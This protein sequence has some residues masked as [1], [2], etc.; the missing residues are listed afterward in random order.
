M[1]YI[2]VVQISSSSSD[3]VDS[4]DYDTHT[5]RCMRLQRQIQSNISLT[6]CLLGTY[7]STYHDKNEPRTSPLSG[8]DWV[9]KTLNT[10]GESHRMFRIDESIFNTLHDLLVTNYGLKSSNHI[11]SME[12]LAI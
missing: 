6:A 4:E 8:Y 5:L 12:S 9:I 11:N 7:Y 2:S 10:P 3:S 1:L